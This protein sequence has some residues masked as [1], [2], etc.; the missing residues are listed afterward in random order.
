MCMCI[1]TGGLQFPSCMMPY[2]M[3]VYICILHAY[4]HK[5]T[6][7]HTH[8]HT[9]A[10]K[11]THTKYRRCLVKTTHACTHMHAYNAYN[12][13]ITCNAHMHTF[14]HTYMHTYSIT[15]N[16]LMVRVKF[17]AKGTRCGEPVSRAVTIFEEFK[18][19]HVAIGAQECLWAH[20]TPVCMY[21]CRH[22]YMHTYSI[23]TISL[24]K[25]DAISCGSV[26]MHTHT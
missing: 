24:I 17:S 25:Q 26:Y 11:T 23:A 13:Y 20:Y 5:H 6:H 15:T 19:S 18:T 2:R 7:T 12:A 9:V 1:Y 10:H 21:T 22:A 14:I 8:K 16:S 3:N 4:A